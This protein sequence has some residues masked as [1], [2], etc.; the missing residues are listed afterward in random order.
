MSCP[1]PHQGQGQK[2]QCPGRAHPGLQ[3]PQLFSAPHALHTGELE[4]LL[5][6]WSPQALLMGLATFPGLGGLN[7][8]RWSKDSHTLFLSISS[9]GGCPVPAGCGAGHRGVQAE[10]S[11]KGL[12]CSFS[13]SLPERLHWQLWTR[14]HWAIFY[15]AK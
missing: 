2:R 14:I 5:L 7:G 15:S 4:G 10:T 12:H 1:R 8:R 11:H 13:R 3:R 6:P 9:S